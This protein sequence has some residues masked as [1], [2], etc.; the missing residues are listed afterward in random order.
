MKQRWLCLVT[1][2]T[3][4]IGSGV[5]RMGLSTKTNRVSATISDEF[6]NV[7]LTRELKEWTEFKSNEL[8]SR[9]RINYESS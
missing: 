9:V 4:P 8:I 6:G 1:R 7:C 3:L 2:F 5:N